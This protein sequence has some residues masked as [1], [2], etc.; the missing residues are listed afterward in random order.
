MFY[1]SLRSIFKEHGFDITIEEGLFQT[2]FLDIK[3]N[4]KDNI[5]KPFKTEIS[6][7]MYINNES[8]HSKT[9]RKAINPMINQRLSNLSSDMHVF[10]DRVNEALKQWDW[11]LKRL[12][13]FWIYPKNLSGHFW[14]IHSFGIVFFE[15]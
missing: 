12:Y 2:D 15:R 14:V 3:L 13:G 1:T 6:K 4:L 10:N 7:I 11:Q 9:I 5:Y 8:N